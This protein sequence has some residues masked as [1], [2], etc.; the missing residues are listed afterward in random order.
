MFDLTQPV[1]AD[2]IVGLILFI[3]ALVGAGLVVVSYYKKKKL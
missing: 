2:V 1:K 3:L